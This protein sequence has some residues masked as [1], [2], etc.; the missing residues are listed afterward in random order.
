MPAVGQSS[1]PSEGDI[2]VRD[3]LIAS[4]EALLNV[5]RCLFN[6]DTQIVPG[7]CLDGSPV[8]NSYVIRVFVGTPTST[9]LESR[10][11]LIASQEALLNVYRCLFNVDTQVVPGGC[12]GNKPTP[13]SKDITPIAT[14]ITPTQTVV[15]PTP[16]AVVTIDPLTVMV[17]PSSSG[18]AN[19]TGF[20]VAIIFARPV[21][22]FDD[23]YLTVANG[24]VTSFSGS[25]ASYEA[26][27][28]PQATG[29]VVVR[30]PAG[31]GHDDNGIYNQPSL[32]YVVNNN[33]NSGLGMDTWNR[34]EVID[35]T[36]AEFQRDEPAV[37]FTGNVDECITGTTSQQYRDS[38]FQRINWY[39][40]MAGVNPV[41]ENPS[42]TR[43][44]QAAALIMSAHHYVSHYPGDD[45][46]CYTDNGA[47][48]ARSSNL[49]FGGTSGIRA[50]DSYMQDSGS[51]NVAVGHRQWILNPLVTSMGT[52]EIPSSS[53][54]LYVVDIP[55]IFSDSFEIR[56][57]RKFVS[58][59]PSGYS[60]STTNWGRWSFKLIGQEDFANLSTAT[61]TVSDDNGIVQIE[62]IFKDNESI[63]WAM[64][65]D[66]DSYLQPAPTSGDHCYTITINNIT[67]LDSS[68]V[69]TQQ[70]PYEYMTC[71]FK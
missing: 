62:V 39:R 24:T 54:A 55:S 8:Q 26:M 9:D 41:M 43:D 31:A 16:T 12:R 11:S 28:E 69:Y 40:R 5:Y 34:S 19:E 32:P 49:L 30:V 22:G 70:P 36:I 29:E 14:A 60:P 3:E 13:S 27:V 42:Y 21:T 58:W 61:V 25:G 48:G 67:S 10:D 65:G 66:T 52:G 23:S 15:S 44:A 38:I 2:F 20:R 64:N 1:T 35:A 71:I 59:P 17:V 45:W 57:P 47:Q 56:Q 37:S 18:Y 63:V 68:Q 7:G 50:I 53:N 6:V 4:Q 46:A 51:S 33:F